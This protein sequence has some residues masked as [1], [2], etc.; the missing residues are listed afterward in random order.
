M[1]L[2]NLYLSSETHAIFSGDK[3]NNMMHHAYMLVDT[4]TV[5]VQE[6]ARLLASE[7]FCTDICAPCYKCLE[8]RKIKNNTQSDLEVYHDR[9]TVEDSRNISAHIHLSPFE[10]KYKIYII[11]NF[12]KATIQAQNALLKTLEEPSRFVI[13][14]LTASN[15][16]NV[17]I[18]VKSRVKQI[19]ERVLTDTDLLS[20]I[21]DDRRVDDDLANKVTS[22]AGGNLTLA[23]EIMKNKNIS[24][25]IALSEDIL[26]NLKTSSH[27][28]R[29]VERASKLKN[30]T[31]FILHHLMALVHKFALY[32][33][34]ENIEINDALKQ[35]MI[36]NNKEYTVVTLKKITSHINHALE[37][38]SS[39]CG[40]VAVF[41]YLL[42]SIL[43]EKYLN[44]KQ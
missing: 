26:F 30:D 2:E 16:N 28:I 37:R 41:D 11:N 34:N 7:I 38:L 29:F 24:E 1:N 17:A 27:V 19:T 31:N 10:H 36:A 8:C 23:I 22:L 43:E 12:D 4:D 42:L 15:E 32:L 35:K 3:V 20:I 9:L 39:N 18:T 13:F 14:I 5:K 40:H 33:T 44:K 6:F 25:I 21:K